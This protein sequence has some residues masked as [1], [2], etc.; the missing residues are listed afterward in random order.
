MARSD[1]LDFEIFGGV[2]GKLE[3]FGGE[4]FQNSSDVDGSLGAYAH[5]VLGVVLEE[6]LYTT[7]RELEEKTRQLYGFIERHLHVNKYGIAWRKVEKMRRV[8]FETKA[9]S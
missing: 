3:D 7:A 6:T 9:A 5:L 1:A 2:P 8:E 4:I